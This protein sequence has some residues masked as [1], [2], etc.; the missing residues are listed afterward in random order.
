MQYDPWARDV[1]TEQSRHRLGPLVCPGKSKVTSNTPRLQGLPWVPPLCLRG[2][3]S[4]L[5][6]RHFTAPPRPGR[7]S[8]T[9]AT[10]PCF[11]PRGPQARRSG[12][13][14]MPPPPRSLSNLVPTCP[15]I[16]SQGLEYL[17]SERRPANRGALGDPCTGAGCGTGQVLEPRVGPPHRRLSR[18]PA[19]PALGAPARRTG[20]DGPAPATP[21]SQALQTAPRVLPWTLLGTSLAPP[22]RVLLAPGPR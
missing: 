11:P 4:S 17:L 15:F 5:G 2:Q 12:A 14:L 9:L 7:L 13:D 6:P 3:R 19:A 20:R 1:S 8:R 16:H 22:R 10:A 18:I 21:R